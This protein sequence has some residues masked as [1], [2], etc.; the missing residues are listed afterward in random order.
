MDDEYELLSHDEIE[1]L[2]KEAEKYKKNP[3]IK[4]GD[5]EKL[6][7]SIIE[8]TAALNK[9]ASVFEDVKRQIAK[10]EERGE[11]PDAKLDKLLDQNKSIAR[12]LFSLGEKLDGLAS[13]SEDVEDSNQESVDGQED[14][15]S[16]QN[17]A[18][19]P[20]SPGFGQQPPSQQ[21]SIQR[22]APSQQPNN[23]S[24]ESF[25]NA[26]PTDM[27]YRSW[28]YGI[29]SK[30]GV[31]YSAQENMDQSFSNPQPRPQ[32]QQQTNT[33]SYPQREP[34]QAIPQ[35]AQQQSTFQQ[36]F[37]QEPKTD[38][39]FNQGFS[40]EAQKDKFDIQRSDKFPEYNPENRDI[41]DL[42]PIEKKAPIKKKTKKFGL[43]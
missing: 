2:K 17:F 3:F 21:Q 39:F 24:Q 18:G 25:S 42:K 4:S 37:N 30:P 31:S 29:H 12:A 22:P 40:Q 32:P 11:G 8:L 38:A 34:S 14:D 35:S 36:G 9:M 26:P 6:Y 13:G 1:R 19:E 16:N 33:V 27:D 7:V 41:P 43:F 15:F 28:N 5:D 20:V 23:F 10:E